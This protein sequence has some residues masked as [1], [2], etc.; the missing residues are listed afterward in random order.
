M[1]KDDR[2]VEDFFDYNEITDEHKEAATEVLKYLDERGA[3]P[4]YLSSRLRVKFG[5][6]EVEKHSLSNC[7]FHRLAMQFGI[8]CK[9]NG[10]MTDEDGSQVPML[11]VEADMHRL[12]EFLEYARIVLSEE[13][14][15]SVVDVE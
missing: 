5:I 7:K 9:E 15:N 3:V 14:N 4:D 13:E 11:R 8:Y 2:L 10:Y 6:K 12:D 1:A